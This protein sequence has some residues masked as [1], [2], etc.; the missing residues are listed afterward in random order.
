M[1]NMTIDKMGELDMARR[2]GRRNAAVR[3]KSYQAKCMQCKRIRR[4]MRELR[5]LT[6]N[7]QVH[8]EANEDYFEDVD[9]IEFRYFHAFNYRGDYELSDATK[10]RVCYVGAVAMHESETLV[11]VLA[12]DVAEVGCPS[13]AP[14]VLYVGS[15]KVWN[16]SE[17]VGELLKDRLVSDV[18]QMIGDEYDWVRRRDKEQPG[19]EYEWNEEDSEDEDA[20][21]ERDRAFLRNLELSVEN[22]LFFLNECYEIGD[23]EWCGKLPVIWLQSA[24]SECCAFLTGCN[25]A[26]G[27]GAA[28]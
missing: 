19:D 9:D 28:G 7:Q 23:F 8:F 25:S 6:F 1:G 3:H 4:R 11:E 10:A 24:D 18:L 27:V 16:K 17:E 14:E 12:K 13:R 26:V 22:L 5:R 2:A 21:E 20:A 15:F